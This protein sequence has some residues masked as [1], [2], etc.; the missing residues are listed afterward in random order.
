MRPVGRAPGRIFRPDFMAV[1]PFATV[2]GA[3]GRAR[4]SFPDRTVR[5]VPERPA[6]RCSTI[7]TVHRILAADGLHHQKVTT[8]GRCEP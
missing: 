5:I 1:T 4:R 3:R 8:T 6:D 7:V 2:A